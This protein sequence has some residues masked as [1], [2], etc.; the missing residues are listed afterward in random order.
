MSSIAENLAA[1]KEQMAQAACKSGREP[2][3]VRLVAVSKTVP[4]ERIEVSGIEG[5]VLGE[6]KIQE[7][8][9]KIADL[10]DFQVDHS[11]GSHFFHNIS[12]AGIPYLFIKYHSETDFIDWDWLDTQET[13]SET[14]YFRHLRLD[15][16][17]TVIANGKERTGLVLK[18]N[19]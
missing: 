10:A 15:K 1:V 18:P 8:R 16:P 5:C 3:A 9:D 19:L 11:Q 13:E 2:D 6:N 4:A 12:S 7:A 14:T 17:L